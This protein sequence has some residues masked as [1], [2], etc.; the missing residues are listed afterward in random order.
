MSHSQ[1]H[2]TN[3]FILR[4]AWLNLW[5][6]H[7]TTGR[8]NQVT[9][10]PVTPN[11]RTGP[12]KVGVRPLWFKH[13]S[14][15]LIKK[16][17]T[18]RECYWIPQPQ[19][20]TAL[21]PDLTFI[22]T[23]CF[24]FITTRMIVF[25]EEL[26]ATSKNNCCCSPSRGGFPTAFIAASLAHQQVVHIPHS[27]QAQKQVLNMVQKGKKYSGS[28][29]IPNQHILLT[30]RNTSLIRQRTSQ[31]APLSLRKSKGILN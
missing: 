15:S 12:R 11:T 1:F 20:E 9:T 28:K 6:K 13:I 21:F 30:Y 19:I 10:F 18:Q 27:L 24:L 25:G 16:P 7:M 31:P 2:S 17:F 14:K 29:S 23:H 4:H 3:L 26:P 22:Q 8:I 5:D